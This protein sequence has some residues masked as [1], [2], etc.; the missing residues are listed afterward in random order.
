[1]TSKIEEGCTK[2]NIELIVDGLEKLFSFL[3]AMKLVRYIALKIGSTADCETGRCKSPNS[4]LSI[5][6]EGRHN[7]VPP[8]FLHDTC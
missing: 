3:E 4:N 6:A 7:L 1:M 8:S 5:P 2:S